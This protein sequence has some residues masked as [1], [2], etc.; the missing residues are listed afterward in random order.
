[1]CEIARM[2][3]ALGDGRFLQRFFTEAEQAYIRGRGRAAGQSMAGCYA[4]KE[5]VL[6]ALGCGIVVP[7][8]AVEIVHDARG[9]PGVQLHGEAL[10]RMT[11]RGG[12]AWHLSITH[13]GPMAAAVAVLE[14]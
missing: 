7:L 9:A 11:E 14:G 13:D 6:K 3:K 2:E 8:D 1:M 4:A 5:A 12:T 10:A